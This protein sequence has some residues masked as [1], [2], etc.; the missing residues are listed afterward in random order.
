MAPN[1][2]LHKGRV[3]RKA[4]L[5]SVVFA[6]KLSFFTV[7]LLFVSLLVQPVHKVFALESVVEEQVQAEETEV[8]DDVKIDDSRESD[9]SEEETLN[10]TPNLDEAVDV[11]SEETIEDQDANEAESDTTSQGSSNSSNAAATSTIE[12]I[13]ETEYEVTNEYTDINLLSDSDEENL[14]SDNEET[15]AV[16]KNPQTLVSDDN[17]YQFSKESCV[18]VGDGTFHCAKA[19]DAKNDVN[20]VVYAELG[21]NKNMEIFLRTSKG[22]V[23]QITQNY[24]D[25]TAP[26]YD[27]DSMRIVWQRLIDGRYQIMTYDIIEKEETQLTFSRTNNME[28]KVSSEGIVWQAWDGKDWEIMYFDGTYT[29]QITDNEAQ[30]VTPVID[31]GYILWSVLGSEEQEAKVYTLSNKQTTTI[32]GY[33]GGTIANPRFVLVYDTKFDNGDIVTQGFDPLTGLSAPISAEPAQE[34]VNIPESD[35][36][37][38]IRALIQNKSHD[39]DEFDIDSTSPDSGNGSPDNASSTT[40]LAPG[41]LILNQAS[42]TDKAASSTAKIISSKQDLVENNF[43]LSEYDL[44]ITSSAVDGVK[45]STSTIDLSNE[46]IL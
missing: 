6:S 12:D 40:K 2:K 45:V 34:P 30:D 32:T 22:S 7:M 9:F 44:V 23:E 33:Q 11:T 38:E 26:F 36:I 28:P 27:A 19:A 5:F 25:D 31:D 39:E 43:E 37:G 42:S 29:D 21:E 10:S 41:T 46:S 17:F 18:A 8:A 35:P 24:F 13:L 3:N 14:D 4:W 16:V 20:A 15:S 1:L